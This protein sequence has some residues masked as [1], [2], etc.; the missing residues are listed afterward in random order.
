MSENKYARRSNHIFA[1]DQMSTANRNHFR[2][3]V[4]ELRH[5]RTRQ[6]AHTR[7]NI[8]DNL[9]VAMKKGER[10]SPRMH[11]RISATIFIVFGAVRGLLENGAIEIQVIYEARRVRFIAQ[12]EKLEPLRRS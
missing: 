7:G 11:V 3:A 5:I 9:L 4:F 2:G 12:I 6:F 8:A 10:L 1:Q